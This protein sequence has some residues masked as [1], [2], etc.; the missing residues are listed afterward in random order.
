MEMALGL[1]ENAQGK[2]SKDGMKNQLKPTLRFCDVQHSGAWA[3]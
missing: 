3:L 1:W 2:S